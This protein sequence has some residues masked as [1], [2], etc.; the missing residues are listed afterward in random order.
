MLGYATDGYWATTKY[1]PTLLHPYGIILPCFKIK[2]NEPNEIKL[3][4]EIWNKLKGEEIHV[5]SFHS[6]VHIF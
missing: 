2:F 3:M 5:M 1:D 6:L 4:W